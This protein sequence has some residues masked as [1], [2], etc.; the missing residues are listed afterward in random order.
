MEIEVEN[1]NGQQYVNPNNNDNVNPNIQQY[2]NPYLDVSI[3]F[4][5]C[6]LWNGNV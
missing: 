2:I 6:T 5:L 1:P 4:A 3:L